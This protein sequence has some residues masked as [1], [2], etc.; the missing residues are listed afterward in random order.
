MKYISWKIRIKDTYM[1]L[2]I[3][4]VSSFL[5][6]PFISHS[7]GSTRIPVLSFI[8]LVGIIFTFRT[9]N[10]R[11]RIFL[12]VLSIGSAWYLC[13]LMLGLF[14]HGDLRDDLRMVSLTMYCLF[15]MATIVLLVHKMFS[16]TEVTGDTIMGGISVYLLL[17][18]LWATF[19]T[20][21][22]LFDPNAFHFSEQAGRA[23]IFY[24]SFAT[25]TTL[26]FGDIYPINRLAMSLVTL[27]VV[28]GQMYLAI[29]ISRLVGLHLVKKSR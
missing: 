29:F 10:L 20:I 3:I 9:L 27:E 11:R 16:V 21:I 18:F 4:L 12:T 25:L 24:F 28:A 5:I 13:E 1:H 19:Y 14:I 22:Y 7:R 26:G 8:L 2:L 6:S 15:L 17:G 23:S